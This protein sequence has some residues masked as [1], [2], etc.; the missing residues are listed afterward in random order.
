MIEADRGVETVRIDEEYREGKEVLADIV[1]ILQHPGRIILADTDE[2]DQRISGQ[3]IGGD[4]FQVDA[5]GGTGGGCI[6]R[7]VEIGLDRFGDGVMLLE[8]RE[9]LGFVGFE[10]RI[11][12][13]KYQGRGKGVL[14]VLSAGFDDFRRTEGFVIG[15]DCQRITQNRR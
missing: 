7:E 12:T 6:Q 14:V 2:R 4:N 11:G 5:A 10:D 8:G 3:G 9:V 15:Y 13:V 1:K